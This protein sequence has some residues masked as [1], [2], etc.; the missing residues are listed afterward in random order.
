MKDT[1]QCTEKQKRNPHHHM[2]TQ[3]DKSKYPLRSDNSLFFF[4][5]PPW[6]RPCFALLDPQCQKP[7]FP[8]IMTNQLQISQIPCHP[9]RSRQ[10]FPLVFLFTIPTCL[11]PGC[12]PPPLP[13]LP[14][15]FPHISNCAKGHVPTPSRAANWASAQHTR[16]P[17]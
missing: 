4:S 6:Y 3:I 10:S 14:P 15:K 16:P 7:D 13:R 2:L 12:L 11:F 9:F 17:S 5:S 8:L 1:P